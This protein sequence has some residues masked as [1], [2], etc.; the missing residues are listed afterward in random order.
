MFV[1]SLKYIIFKLNEKCD[2]Y[3]S[4]VDE[5]LASP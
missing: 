5:T 4:P 3:I 2:T 1:H